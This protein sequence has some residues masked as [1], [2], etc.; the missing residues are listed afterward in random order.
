[1]PRGALVFPR[2]LCYRLME[3]STKNELVVADLADVNQKLVCIE[4]PGG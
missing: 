1:M 3:D 4:F 2:P